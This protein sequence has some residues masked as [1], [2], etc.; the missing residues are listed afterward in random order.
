MKRKITEKRKRVFL[1]LLDL[2]ERCKLGILFFFGTSREDTALDCPIAKVVTV[3]GSIL[4]SC[5]I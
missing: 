2:S 3:L 1:N 5:E 4:A